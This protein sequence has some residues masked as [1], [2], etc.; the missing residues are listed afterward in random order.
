MFKIVGKAVGIGE[1]AGEGRNVGAAKVVEK[2]LNTTRIGKMAFANLRRDTSDIFWI[3]Q[4]RSFETKRSRHKENLLV[5]M[6]YI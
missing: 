4:F 2:K 3:I 1:G 6:L 5:L